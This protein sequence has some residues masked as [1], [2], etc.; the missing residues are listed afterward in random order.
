[1]SQQISLLKVEAGR[2]VGA[3]WASWWPHQCEGHNCLRFIVTTE[4]SVGRLPLLSSSRR[5][6]DLRWDFL[7]HFCLPFRWCRETPGGFPN[8]NDII[9]ITELVSFKLRISGFPGIISF[10][11]EM[12]IFGH[13]CLDEYKSVKI[14][15]S[16]A[17]LTRHGPVLPGAGVHNG[18][19][20]LVPRSLSRD[21]WRL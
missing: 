12:D 5:Q 4:R 18:V 13:N 19:D 14:T 8:S 16:C 10:T 3:Q 7:T 11:L 20:Q 6:G 9:Q 21:R 15:F 1:M 2:K 17:L